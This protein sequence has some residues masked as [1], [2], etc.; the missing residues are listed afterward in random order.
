[1]RMV[2]SKRMVCA[3]TAAALLCALFCGTGEA[4]AQSVEA[5]FRGKSLKLQV[6][7]AV[8]GGADLYARPSRCS[9]TM[10][11]ASIRAG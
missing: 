10:T 5:F 8:G 11:S 4:Q 3:K 1:M 2:C 6:S 7:A 9:P